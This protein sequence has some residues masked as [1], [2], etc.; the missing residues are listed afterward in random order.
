M[1]R[2][3]IKKRIAMKNYIQNDD[4]L[5]VYKMD[6]SDDKSGLLLLNALI[7]NTFDYGFKYLTPPEKAEDSD[8]PG[9]SLI[10]PNSSEDILLVLIYTIDRI[11]TVICNDESQARNQFEDIIVKPADCFE[12]YDHELT[13]SQA[14]TLEDSV[15]SIFYDAIGMSD[16]S[17]FTNL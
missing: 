15:V 11:I 6:V 16:P 9:V 1:K 2:D 17:T 10:L 14:W 8:I 4:F 13:F 5:P 12:D 3:I 7:E